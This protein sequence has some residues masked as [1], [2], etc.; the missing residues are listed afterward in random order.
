VFPF[1]GFPFQALSAGARVRTPAPE[2]LLMTLQAGW[3]VHAYALPTGGQVAAGNVD[4]SKCAVQRLD[5]HSSRTTHKGVHRL[6]GVQRR[7]G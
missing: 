1:S 3:G 2:P 6:A 5:E 4:G 7:R